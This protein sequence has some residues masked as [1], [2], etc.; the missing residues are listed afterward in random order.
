MLYDKLMNPKG[1][2]T[3]LML[4]MLL[5]GSL[6]VEAARKK[7]VQKIK[8]ACVGNSITYGTGIQDREHF[9]YPVQLQKMLGDKYLVGNFGKPGATL[10]KHG[11][12]PYMKQEEYRQAMA[13]KGDIAVIHLGINDTDP[14]N[15]PNYRDEFVKDY[16]SLMDSLR[17]ANPKVRFL[18]GSNDL[19]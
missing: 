5:T 11:H 1:A 14:R 16:L 6:S 3:A 13:F 12:R 17:S 7:T 9:S 4:S 8:V 2:L 19:R 15:W 18:P 10:L